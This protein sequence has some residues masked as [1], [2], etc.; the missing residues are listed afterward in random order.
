[1]GAF[2]KYACEFSTFTNKW[3]DFVKLGTNIA[4]DAM[5]LFPEIMKIL[6]EAGPTFRERSNIVKLLKFPWWGNMRLCKCYDLFLVWKKSNKK[7][8]VT[9]IWR[10]SPKLNLIYPQSVPAVGSYPFLRVPDESLSCQITSLRKNAGVKIFRYQLSAF[11]ANIRKSM[12][13]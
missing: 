5:F 6:Q 3:L 13:H 11:T 8:I 1:M 4:S 7:E 12:I 10:Q 2:V 9:F